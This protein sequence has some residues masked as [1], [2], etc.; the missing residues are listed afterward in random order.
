MRRKLLSL[1]LADTPV[2]LTLAC[3]LAAFGCGRPVGP[4]D[5]AQLPN[6]TLV[7]VRVEY[8]QPAACL[9]SNPSCANRVVFF[10]SWLPPGSEFA[11][12][13]VSG[14]RIWRATADD[15]P[16]NYPPK[17]EPY[18][19]RIFDPFIAASAT[20]GI[21]ANRITVGGEFLTKYSYVGTTSEGALVFI[22][23]NGQG[24]NAF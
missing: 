1:R 2:P 3:L 24:H 19:V 8:V 10:A 4:E 21:T 13:L 16:V 6:P 14:T 15:V 23:V 7:S 20:R 12:E 22:D 5:A 17:G 9:T 11:L 18:E